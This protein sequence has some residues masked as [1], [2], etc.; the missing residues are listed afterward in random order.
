MGER[1]VAK[2]LIAGSVLIAFPLLVW[3][4]GSHS[5]DHHDDGYGDMGH[6][7]A[8]GSPE[9]ASRAERTVRVDLLDSM[10]FFFDAPLD[11]RRGEVVRFEVTNRGSIRH[12]FS[13]G[14]EA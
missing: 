3:A 13:I 7:S 14:N 6:K 2:K 8:V 5:E 9:V 4:G 11:L 10:R 12:E 1:G